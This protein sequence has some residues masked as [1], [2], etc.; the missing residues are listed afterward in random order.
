[1]RRQRFAASSWQM[2]HF[3]PDDRAGPGSVLDEPRSKIVPNAQPAFARLRRSE[4]LHQRRLSRRSSRMIHASEGG[5]LFPRTCDSIEV[6]NLRTSPSI[7]S[8]ASRFLADFVGAKHAMV[9]LLALDLSTSLR[10]DS[11]P[12]RHY[13]GRATDVDERLEWHNAG[14]CGYTLQHRPWS[15]VVSESRTT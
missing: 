1:L 14:P 4:F 13:V 7:L 9:I 10:S 15:I 2:H 8:S 5:P 12:S 6:H 3:T 11:D